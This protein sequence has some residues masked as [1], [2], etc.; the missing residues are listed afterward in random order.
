[1]GM[2]PWGLGGDNRAHPK[3]TRSELELLG[4]LRTEPC[5][6]GLG[7]PVAWSQREFLALPV[8]GAGMNATLMTP[9]LGTRALKSVG[10]AGTQTGRPQRASPGA[11]PL[12]GSRAAMAREAGPTAPRA[13]KGWVFFA[14]VSVATARRRAH[15]HRTTLP[16]PT[17]WPAPVPAAATEVSFW[18][19]LR[20]CREA[21]WVP[22]RAQARE[23]VPLTTTPPSPR[24][25]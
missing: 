20:F 25:G 7:R 19:N 23:V 5:P 11:H 8:M 9:G 24:T 14:C 12:P 15:A 16:S 22:A 17:H 4:Q 6:P 13:R 1:M 18:G 2:G 21:G 10:A 3:R